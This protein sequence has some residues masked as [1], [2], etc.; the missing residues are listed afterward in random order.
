M[1]QA[2]IVHDVNKIIGKPDSS[3]WKQVFRPNSNGQK[4]IVLAVDNVSLWEL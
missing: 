1:T 3:I 4:P 2:I